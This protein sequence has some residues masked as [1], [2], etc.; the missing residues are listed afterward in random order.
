[1]PDIA[2]SGPAPS[3]VAHVADRVIGAFGPDRSLTERVALL[4]AA[5]SVG[6]SFEPGLQPRKTRDQAIA[7]GAIGRGQSPSPRRKRTN[8]SAPASAG[9]KAV[10]STQAAW[11]PASSASRPSRGSQAHSGSQKPPRQRSPNR[12]RWPAI[13][14]RSWSRIPASVA[15]SGRIACV[16]L[17]VQATWGARR[18]STSPPHASRAVRDSSY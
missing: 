18:P 9:T 16:A 15:S 12:R 11:I 17:L 1:M 5:A 8:A 13:P 4:V 10:S 14:V 6:P 3:G 2:P 7:T